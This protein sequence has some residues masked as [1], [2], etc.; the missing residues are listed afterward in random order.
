M[1]NFTLFAA[2]N[3]R[4]LTDI[5]L[6]RLRR[7]KIK[8]D[9][10]SVLCPS[11]SIPHAMDC[12][13][14]ITRQSKLMAGPSVI[15]CAGQLRKNAEVEAKATTRG[16]GIFNLLTHAGVD[17][18][19]AHAL[20]ERLQEGHNVVGV[21]AKTEEEALIALQVFRHAGAESIV[22]NNPSRRGSTRSAGRLPA[23]LS[24][25]STAA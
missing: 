10:I 19:G 24:W 17:A 6:I 18:M 8:C 21:T 15:T 12:W 14:P 7:A 4:L 16:Q 20:I 22:V 2:A 5:I 9:A 11:N 13:L 1:S 25:V 3:S 23:F